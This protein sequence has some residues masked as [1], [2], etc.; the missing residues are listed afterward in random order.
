MRHFSRSILIMFLLSGLLIAACSAP[1]AA[2]EPPPE[3]TEGVE[4]GAAAEETQAESEEES[5][6]QSV[7]VS[8]QDVSTGTVTIEEVVSAGPGWL[9]IHISADGDPGPIIGTA[10]VEAGVTRDLVVDIDAQRATEQLFAMLHVDAGEA[11]E[12]EFPEGPDVPATRGD[13][14]VNVPFSV[15]LPETMAGPIV[16]TSDSPFGEILVD[17]EGLTLYLFTND[18]PGKSTCYD[19]CAANWPALIVDG[20]F[21]GGEGIDADLLAATTRDDG[22][23]QVTYNGW[24]LYYYVLDQSPGDVSGQGVGGVW[25]VVSPSGAA[26]T[27]TGG[28]D[29]PDY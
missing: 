14:I 27:G 21:I 24:P 15:V 28:D 5:P 4:A 2:T 10:K 26:V 11:G 29:L 13:A 7:A 25:F 20:D 17:A 6:V 3:P 23:M 18:T 12:F 19:G 16:E 1:E 9:V 22:S 8:D